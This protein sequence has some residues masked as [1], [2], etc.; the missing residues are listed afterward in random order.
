MKNL[1]VTIVFC[2]LMASVFASGTKDKGDKPKTRTEKKS[3]SIYQEIISY[4][5]NIRYAHKKEIV[6]IAFKLDPSGNVDIIESNSSN[7]EF[8]AYVSS[9]LSAADLSDDGLSSTTQYLKITFIS[10]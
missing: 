2:C 7:P 6:L 10:R 5:E 3:N 8:L 1:T 9:K 4:P